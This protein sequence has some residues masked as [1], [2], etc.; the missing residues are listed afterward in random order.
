LKILIICVDNK[1][2]LITDDPIVKTLF[3]GTTIGSKYDFIH[4]RY[5]KSEIKVTLYESG[6]TS[7]GSTKL[8]LNIGWGVLI[9]N[10]YKDYISPDDKNKILRTIYQTNYRTTPFSNLRDYQN[11]D[12]LHLLKYKYGL[13]C[14]YTSYGKTELIAT[15][16]NYLYSELKLKVLLLVPSSKCKDELVKRCKERFNINVPSSD[17][18]LDIINSSGVTSSKRFKKDNKEEYENTK[19]YL[20][21]IDCVLADEVEYVIGG[22]GG[23]I[24]LDMCKN[25]YMRY[26]FSGTADKI[27]GNLITFSNGITDV[28]I[29]NRD[30]IGY[31]GQALIYRVPIHLDINL[32]TVKTSCFNNITFTDENLSEDSNIYQT[33]LNTM[34]TNPESCDMITKLIKYYPR[35]FIPINNLTNIIDNWISNY[36]IGKFRILLICGAGYIYYDLDRNSRRVELSEACDLIKNDEVDVIPS[37]S[38][39]F[40]ALDLPG[41]TNILLIQGKIAGVVL[42]SIGRVARGKVA[43]IIDLRPKPYKPI[44]VYTK[45][46]R[47]RSNMIKKYYKY[48]N[49]NLITRDESEFV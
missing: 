13:F 23:K 39:G 48:C 43:N 20:E 37:T 7:K 30:L 33:V 32:V 2:I 31:F 35:L 4:K 24:V 5:I 42:Q 9:L 25:A 12:I 45:G 49:L 26:G 21:S 15:L 17:G 46:V 16:V 19:N 1:I 34:W 38:S 29:N 27:G 44:P 18:L 11:D 6:R 10:L 41:L 36:W 40:R 8:I 3:S 22:N 14:N 28:V 47:D